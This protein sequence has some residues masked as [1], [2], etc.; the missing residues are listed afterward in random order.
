MTAAIID[1][2]V[3]AAEAGTASTDQRFSHYVP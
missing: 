3:S 1:G 2:S